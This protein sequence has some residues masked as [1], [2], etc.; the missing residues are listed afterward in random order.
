MPVVMQTLHAIYLG[1]PRS[2]MTVAT[3]CVSVQVIP[4][5]SPPSLLVTVFCSVSR[6]IFDVLL[7]F[8]T[9]LAEIFLLS[10]I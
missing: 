8:H 3:A 10:L 5:W 1:F 9:V 7:N 6:T 2:A 4:C